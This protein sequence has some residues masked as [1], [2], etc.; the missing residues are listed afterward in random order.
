MHIG[1][2]GAASISSK[3]SHS[4]DRHRQGN[5]GQNLQEA[6]LPNRLLSLTLKGIYHAGFAPVKDSHIRTG[7]ATSEHCF[8]L[9]NRRSHPIQG[10]LQVGKRHLCPLFGRA[11]LRRWQGSRRRESSKRAPP[12]ACF[13][14]TNSRLITPA[15]SAQKLLRV[16]HQN[17]D[18]LSS[19]QAGDR[20]HVS[21]SRSAEMPPALRQYCPRS[22]RQDVFA[23]RRVM[24]EFR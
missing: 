10:G 4:I 21:A 7:Q 6:N 3:S 24:P 12:S 22:S 16:W 2:S 17:P 11:T 9:G 8:L 1:L 15:E 14:T 23:R 20:A 13:R 18:P 5:G 19:R